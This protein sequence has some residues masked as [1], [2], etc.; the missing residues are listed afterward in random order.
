PLELF[1]IDTEQVEGTWWFIPLGLLFVWLLLARRAGGRLAKASQLKSLWKPTVGAIAAYM[2]F[3][4]GTPT[5]V[6]L[7]PV[8]ISPAVATLIPGAVFV[9]G[10]TWGVPR[11]FRRSIALAIGDRVERFP[12]TARALGHYLWAVLRA[13]VMSLA[14]DCAFASIA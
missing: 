14:G 8:I 10:Y 4:W 12:D 5:P 1:N 13:G 11:H 7:Y 2:F 6:K 3:V 9:I